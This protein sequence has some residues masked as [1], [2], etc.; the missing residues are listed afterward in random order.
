MEDKGKSSEREKG[1]NRVARKRNR[2][3]THHRASKE[4]K[5]GYRRALEDLAEIQ[6]N[7][8]RRPGRPSGGA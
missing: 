4:F 3:L 1:R 2:P 6:R 8:A 5:A 7:R